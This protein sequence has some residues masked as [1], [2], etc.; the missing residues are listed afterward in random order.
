MSIS[1]NSDITYL[2]GVGERRSALYNKLGIFT[3]YDLITYYPRKYVDFTDVKPISQ[4]E[5][6]E[7]S[8]FKGRVMNRLT[9]W[10]SR[11]L[12]V[13]KAVIS[14]G[15]DEIVAVIFNSEYSFNKLL[16][17][18]EFYFYGKIGGNIL[19]KEIGSPEFISDDDFVKIRPKYSLTA[20]LSN[21]MIIKHLKTA[22][23]NIVL[24]DLI[25]DY[26]IKKHSLISFSDA[27]FKIHFPK[28]EEDIK[29]A[30]KRLIFEEFLS[31]QLAM[32]RLKNK[33][34]QLTSIKFN[35]LNIDDFLSTMPFT[36]TNAQMRSINECLSDFGKSFPM[37]RLLQGDVGS[38][39]TLVAAAICWVAAKSNYQSAVMVP[40]EIL[41][42]QHYT[43]FSSMLK[44]FGISCALLI[45]SMSAAE[46]SKV[47]AE[48]K[49]GE[50]NIIIGTHTLIQKSVKFN[51]L[52]LVIADE[53]HRFGVNQRFGLISKGKNPHCLVM[54]A[55]PIPRT[56]ALMIYGDLDISV[57]D[58]MP[59]G[60]LPV[61]TYC[62]DSSFHE[63]LYKFIIK[64]VNKGFQ[65]YIVCPLIEENE[66]NE[67]KAATQYYDTLKNSWF[68]NV[69]LALLHGKMKQSEKDSV[70]EAFRDNKVQVLISTTV[71]EVGID[72]PDAVIMII[73]NAEQFGLSQLHQ[74]RGRVGRGNE[75]SYCILVTD[76][77]NEVAKKRMDIMKSSND[78]FVVANED[79][80]LRGPGEFFG[81][82]QHGL[83]QLKIADLADDI[84][85]LKIVQEESISIIK[86]DPALDNPAN[87]GLKLL[88]DKIIGKGERF[89]YN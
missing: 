61:I 38:G 17:G 55:T 8:A 40:T 51:N 65:A 74:L 36:P 72:V 5:I 27:V 62:V 16:I 29:K 9:P 25:P 41:A 52:G 69:N 76:S 50:I 60:R 48:L 11:G 4:L 15:S 89:G 78:G 83:P 56:L 3:V 21:E 13:Y 28:D 59:K 85:I 46:K 42:K 49:N 14:D 22:M 86:S 80:K 57:I 34:R 10:Y 73:E 67:K 81:K 2:K 82:K 64:Y 35:N 23:S 66:A 44:D 12:T 18:K 1:A 20:G 6:G 31:L 79:L 33:N 47:K 77:K 70:M 26:L 43:T 37:N 7:T 32:S 53:Q 63:R 71:I 24:E 39:K 19:G 84:E 45:G 30:R 58:E 88:A 87:K 54:S 75:Q 68:N